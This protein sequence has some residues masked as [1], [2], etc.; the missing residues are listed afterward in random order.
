MTR[1][2]DDN[3]KIRKNDR[4][5]LKAEAKWE[6]L[7]KKKHIRKENFQSIISIDKWAFYT[8]CVYSSI[9]S[10]EILCMHPSHLVTAYTTASVRYWVLGMGRPRTSQYPIHV[11]YYLNEIIRQL[12]NFNWI[13]I[14]AMHKTNLSIESNGEHMFY[15]ICIEYVIY[16]N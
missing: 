9:T 11:I 13:S 7:Q 12:N 6:K 3:N 1:W 5:S 2:K 15:L 8:R 16:I 14:Y 4:K 10:Q